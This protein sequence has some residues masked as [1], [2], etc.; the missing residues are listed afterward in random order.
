[1]TDLLWPGD[2]RAGEI[3]S[4]GAVLAAMIR[5][6]RAWLDVLAG[7]GL[8]P[9][10]ALRGLELSAD[11]EAVA[12]A[13][14]QTGNPVPALVSALRAGCVAS[15]PVA[16]HWLH[17]GLTSQD[18]LDTALAMCL[19][20]AGNRVMRELCTQAGLLAELARTH[21]DAVAPGRTLG[22]PAVPITFGLTA[23]TWLD[24]VLDGIDDLDWALGRLPAQVGGAAGT[25]A[26]VTELTGDPAKAVAAG[27]RLASMLQLPGRSPWQTQRRPFTRFA[28][29]LV[30]CTDAWGHIAN[31]V[32]LRS[33]PEFGELSEGSVA[34]RGG[35]STLPGKENPVVSVLIRRAAMMAPGLAGQVHLA[36]AS[37]VDERPDGAWH[38][39]WAPLRTLG[40]RA[41]V[42]GSQVT[43]LLAGL[44][45]HPGRMRAN[46]EEVAGVL[47]AERDAIRAAR[48][49]P[50]EQAGVDDYL[51]AAGLLVDTTLSSGI[52]STPARAMK[53]LEGEPR[54]GTHDHSH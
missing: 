44:V 48:G 27:E 25:L 18:V 33:R 19:R 16:A 12:G 35:S 40:R 26:A 13:A 17:R 31:D 4:D 9:E 51:G 43:E 20:D 38:T 28:D 46:A 47:L 50:A 32:L 11:R 52:D 2:Q 37:M 53:Y 45:V 10:D 24:G 29:V 7:L 49:R 6:E 1:V 3:C 34:G 5:V 30:A 14:E 21:R 15:H 54:D 8:F 22:R 42:A 36:A 39:E 23:A 41:V